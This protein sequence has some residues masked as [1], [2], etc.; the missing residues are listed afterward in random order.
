MIVTVALA[1]EADAAGLVK[2]AISTAGTWLHSD[3]PTKTVFTNSTNTYDDTKVQTFSDDDIRIGD[4]AGGQFYTFSTGNLAAD[5]TISLPVLDTADVFVFETATQTLTGK[6]L[7]GGSNT[8]TNIPKTGIS[9]T[10]TWVAADIPSLDASKITT[11]TMATARLGSNTANS[12]TYLRGDQ[13]WYTI[14]VP[15]D[16]LSTSGTL[17]VG[18]IWTNQG[19]GV[20]ELFTSASRRQTIDTETFNQFRIQGGYTTVNAIAGSLLGLQYSVDGV[21]TWKAP[22]NGTANKISSATIDITTTAPASKVT[23]WTNLTSEAKAVNVLWRIAGHSN[24]AT[25]DPAISFVSVQFR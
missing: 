3:L 25:G 19:L 17:G 23:S 7:D 5:R 8:F 11:G 4:N 12:T 13:N 16:F 22:N 20:V 14:T 9:T 6:T 1:D 10:G 15:Y 18:A 21:T 2:R 24:V